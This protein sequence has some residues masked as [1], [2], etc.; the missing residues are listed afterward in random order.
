MSVQGWLSSAALCLVG[1]VP[2]QAYISL[3]DAFNH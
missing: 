2:T 1:L 3:L